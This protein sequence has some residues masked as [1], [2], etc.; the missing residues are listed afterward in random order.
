LDLLEI[1]DLK[2]EEIRKE[3]LLELGKLYFGQLEKQEEGKKILKKL[4]R[5]FPKE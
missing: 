3:G 5:L 2:D 1:K 4:I